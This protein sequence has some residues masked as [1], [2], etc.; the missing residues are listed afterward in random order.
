MSDDGVHAPLTP[1]SRLLP[2]LKEAGVSPRDSTAADLVISLAGVGKYTGKR[3]LKR[4]FPIGDLY[5]DV[6]HL[7]NECIDVFASA[8]SE[9]ITHKESALLNQ[10]LKELSARMNQALTAV[11]EKVLFASEE[12]AGSGEQISRLSR[13]LRVSQEQAEE[14]ESKARKLEH[15]L[16][17]VRKTI[18]LLVEKKKAA[19]EAAAIAAGQRVAVLIGRNTEISEKEKANAQLGKFERKKMELEFARLRGEILN[20]KDTIFQNNQQAEILQKELIKAN[21]EI[22]QFRLKED[23][24]LQEKERM[25]EIAIQ[26]GERQTLKDNFTSP[27]DAPQIKAVEDTTSSSVEKIETGK[28][29]PVKKS[30]EDKKVKKIHTL[31]NEVISS[32]VSLSN[33]VR[34]SRSAPPPIPVE[35]ARKT[36]FP[37]LR[38]P[39]EHF[40]KEH[41]TLSNTFSSPNAKR[42]SMLATGPLPYSLVRSFVPDPLQPVADAHLARLT[43][44]NATAD[45]LIHPHAVARFIALAEF[46]HLTKEVLDVE[47][48][49]KLLALFTFVQKDVCVK[50]GHV[51]R[52]CRRIAKREDAV[53]E[54]QDVVPPLKLVAPALKSQV[55]APEWKGDS[56]TLQLSA[57]GVTLKD[58]A[59]AAIERTF[60]LPPLPTKAEVL[61]STSVKIPSN[62]S[63]LRTNPKQAPLN[64]PYIKQLKH[65]PAFY[66]MNSKMHDPSE[67]FIGKPL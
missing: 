17:A 21:L 15:E 22:S 29:E 18:A 16:L 33:E 9:V 14:A 51:C 43:S 44:K 42:L 40:R 13:L 54:R 37:P 57:S 59:K 25:R 67:L 10:R 7:T 30:N 20:L 55:S 28:H 35:V 36:Q 1:G 24:R 41:V 47:R 61:K 58:E 53:S 23:E 3:L 19:D 39:L 31:T 32:P 26:A 34:P 65:L 4:S 48:R 50:V 8:R 60:S 64:E 27:I 62:D 49:E 66:A 6:V 56:S 2:P 11:S 45:A 38:S 12:L 5:S 52:F 63:K 46:H